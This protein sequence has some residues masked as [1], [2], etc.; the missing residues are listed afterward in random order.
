MHQ[1]DQVVKPAP[2]RLL[3]ENLEC[4]VRYIY[5][6]NPATLCRGQQDAAGW[7]AGEVGHRPVR[8]PQRKRPNRQR[9]R[10]EGWRGALGKP[11]IPP[12]PVQMVTR[13]PAVTRIPLVTGGHGP[14]SSGKV[15]GV[16]PRTENG[17]GCGTAYLSRDR[18]M[19]RLG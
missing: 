10:H 1:R 11:G 8:Q 4:Q 9:M 3:A 13:H 16:A 14:A 12:D 7:P 18:V 19:V 2:P 6:L 5:R 15:V 17:S